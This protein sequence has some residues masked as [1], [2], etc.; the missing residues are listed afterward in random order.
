MDLFLNLE[1]RI[2]LIGSRAYLK[3]EQR[4]RDIVMYRQDEHTLVRTKIRKGRKKS[5]KNTRT[6]NSSWYDNIATTSL[7]AAPS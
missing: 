1:L 2:A 4:T 7:R 3:S 6:G 5:K